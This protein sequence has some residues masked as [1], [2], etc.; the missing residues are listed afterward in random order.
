M[1]IDKVPEEDIS[2][3]K[4]SA[5]STWIYD[6]TGQGVERSQWVIKERPVTLYLNGREM[7]T[8]LCAG[9]HLD[10]LAVGFF[11][12]EGFLQTRDDLVTLDVEEVAG[13]VRIGT[14]ADVSLPD[15]LWMKR[16]ITSGCGKGSL[17]YYALD[18]LMSRPVKGDI[19]ISPQQVL[20][21]VEELHRLSEIYRRTHGVHNTVLAAPHKALL[22]RDDIGRHNAVDMIVGYAFLNRI[23]LE[24]KILIT[25]GRL[26]SEILI[27]AAKVNIPIIISRNTATTLAIELAHSLNITLIGYA[28]AGKFTVYSGRERIIDAVG[29]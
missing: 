20:D 8:L 18:A 28:R 10:E 23:S 12:A 11:H 5:V 24:D 16:T 19:E 15:R 7:V 2:S 13:K 6:R 27:K 21:R 22:F 26:T 17:F 4:V 14:K 1:T 3:E 9:H 25:T 29:V